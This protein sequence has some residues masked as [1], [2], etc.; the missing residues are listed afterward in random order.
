MQLL[1]HFPIFINGKAKS[2][3]CAQSDKPAASTCSCCPWVTIFTSEK[4]KANILTFFYNMFICN[5]AVARIYTIFVTKKVNMAKDV[6]DKKAHAVSILIAVAL[7]LWFLSLK[8]QKYSVLATSLTYL[9]LAYLQLLPLYYNFQIKKAK[10]DINRIQE[11]MHQS[12]LTEA[13][14]N[15]TVILFLCYFT[16]SQSITIMPA[17]P[18]T[19]K[20]EYSNET[21][22][23][24]LT[25]HNARKSHR[26]IADYIKISKL[27]VSRILQ[28][29]SKNSNKP[30]Y[31]TKRIRW[32]I[33]LYAWS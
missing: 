26:K 17:K 25:L 20:R 23:V 16:N 13:P 2:S 22:S 8:K 9:L 11:V 31:K 29:T 4:A 6:L 3:T 12:A 19:A 7:V 30:Y 24:I 28:Q 21:I 33:K 10:V 5:P 14:T 15:F 18:K 32:S 27:I 1:L